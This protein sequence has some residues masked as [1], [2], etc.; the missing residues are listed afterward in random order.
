MI[1]MNLQNRK[2]L[3]DLEDK[4]MV[5][6]GKGYLGTLGRSC[7]PAILKMENRQ[8][9]C[10]ASGTL[11]S[12]MCKPGLGRVWESMDTYMCMYG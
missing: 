7:T 4:L 12:V 8:R 3:T 5:A 9:H 6:G 11:F 10:I 2:R 1:Q